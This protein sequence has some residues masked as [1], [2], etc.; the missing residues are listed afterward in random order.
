MRP[1]RAW[2]TRVVS[3]RRSSGVVWGLSRVALS[4][5]RLSAWARPSTAWPWVR[6]VRRMVATVVSSVSVGRKRTVLMVGRA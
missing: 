5:R 1:V 2:V 3:R 6:R 4:Q